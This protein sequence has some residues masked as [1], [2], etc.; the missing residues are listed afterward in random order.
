MDSVVTHVGHAVFGENK[1]RGYGINADLAGHDG[2]ASAFSLAIGG[3][4]LDR[5][6]SDVVEDMCVCCLAADPRIWPLKITRL[7]ASYGAVMPAFAAGHLCLEGALVGPD[8]VGR[9]AAT[10]AHWYDQLGDDAED[11][12]A[13]RRHVDAMLAQGRVAGFGVVFRGRDER[14]EAIT[15]C[16]EKRGRESGRHWRLAVAI[17]RVMVERGKVQLNGAMASA[18]VL[19]DLGF[20]A[21]QIRL[22]MATYLDICFYANAMEG[23]EQKSAVLRALPREAVEYVGRA[24]RL[25]P[26]AAA[27]RNYDSQHPVIQ[28]AVFR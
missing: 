5:A 15:E 22:L 27:K 11:M 12:E 10:L 3:P 20:S 16:V 24:E 25:S 1:F 6:D 17:D 13:V 14:V 8:G 26:R 2:W 9:A 18:A 4:R 7:V 23:A 21:P 19:L 28:E